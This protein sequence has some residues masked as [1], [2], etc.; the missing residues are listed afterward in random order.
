MRRIGLPNNRIANKDHL[1]KKLKDS[2]LLVTFVSPLKQANT[3]FRSFL[4]TSR[5]LLGLEEVE[6]AYLYPEDFGEADLGNL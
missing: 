5:R 1:R 6:F 3:Y 4:E 2:Q